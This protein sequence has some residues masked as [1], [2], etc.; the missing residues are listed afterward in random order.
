MT[1]RGHLRLLF[2]H[3]VAIDRMFKG[4]ADITK[5]AHAVTA[6]N[7]CLPTASRVARTGRKINSRGVR[8]LRCDWLSDVI[9]QLPSRMCVL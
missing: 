1:A 4:K 2:D 3:E 5:E 9:S 7:N 8:C 6:I